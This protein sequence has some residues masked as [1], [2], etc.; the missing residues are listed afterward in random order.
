MLDW[1]YLILLIL[2][3]YKGYKNGAIVT[4]FSFLAIFIG[5]L[6]AIK[7][8]TSI[9]NWLSNHWIVT[10]NWFPTIV[11]FIVLVASILLVNIGA[12]ILKQAI[13]MLLLGWFDSLF[14]IIVTMFYFTLIFSITV[15][16]LNKKNVLPNS[17]LDKT[18][19]ANYLLPVGKWALSWIS[20]IFVWLKNV[21]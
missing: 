20:S 7:F 16:F 19:T 4:L 1:F 2:A 17:W 5:L 8:S 18:Y 15:Y 13:K 6:I 3:V 12:R 10:K 21:I 9:H 14:G 11:F